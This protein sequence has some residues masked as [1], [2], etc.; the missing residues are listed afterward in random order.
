MEE[1][2]LWRNQIPETLRTPYFLTREQQEDYYLN[3]ICDRRG[4][5][6][7]FAFVDHED[8]T[9]G[10]GGIENIIWESRIGE[11]SLIVK[12]DLR[13]KGYGKEIVDSILEMAFKQI[14]LDHVFG[15]CYMCGN[16]DFWNKMIKKY[17]A[18]HA[19]LPARKYFDGKYWDSMY[20]T[21]SKDPV[22][23]VKE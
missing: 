15:E 10:M 13:G 20:F 12:P 6:R 1:V 7:Y 2:R 3:T 4:T 19:V 9:I 23:E 14:N 5:T 17:G 8:K 22:C 21:F 16:I 18:S 11:I